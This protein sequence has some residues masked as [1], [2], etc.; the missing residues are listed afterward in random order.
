M[1]NFPKET[2]V[3]RVIAKQKFYDN[4]NIS[5]SLKDCF[6]NDIEKI[7]WANKL[8]PSTMNIA[9]SDKIKEL[10]VFHI[11][12]KTEK[13]NQKILD[14]IDKAI[15][16][17]ILFV[18]EYNGKYQLWLGYKEKV[19]NGTN[20]T[21]ISRY[22]NTS[23]Q[24]NPSL[25]IQGSK[26]ESIYENFLCQLS[27]N[28]I[29]ATDEADLKEKVNKT[30]DIHKLEQQIEKLTK[31]MLAEK[32]FNRQITIRVQIKELEKRLLEMNSGK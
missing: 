3:N 28:L 24:A 1:L 6:V 9:G 13:F 31:K 19:A 15:P 21:S 2:E 32:Q 7:I 29:D 22:F 18:L 12:L 27:D 10:E 16:Y 5:K 14:A 23:W 11:K 8:A 30:I 26:L 4:A 20:K 25:A 17:Y